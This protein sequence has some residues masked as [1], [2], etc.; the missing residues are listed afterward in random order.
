MK[1]PACPL[2]HIVFR[3]LGYGGGR[4]MSQLSPSLFIVHSSRSYLLNLNFRH[5]SR[6]TPKVGSLGLGVLGVV[7]RD[8]R[9]D[10]IFG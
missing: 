2:L 6:R 8:S 4:T 10:C 7:I 9:F 3:F 5:R 1:S